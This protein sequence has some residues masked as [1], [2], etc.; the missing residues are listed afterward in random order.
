MAAIGHHRSCAAKLL[1]E[2]NPMCFSSRLIPKPIGFP[3]VGAEDQFYIPHARV[4]LALVPIECST[5]GFVQKRLS[6]P[7]DLQAFYS[8]RIIA[9]P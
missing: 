1:R 2:T 8:M 6:F 9:L 5:A 3:S 4:H 7:A